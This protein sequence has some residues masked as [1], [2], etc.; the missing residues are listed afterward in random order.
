MR[1][2]PEKIGGKGNPVR[3]PAI[4]RFLLAALFS[5]F[6]PALAQT[7]KPLPGGFRDLKWRAH[8]TPGMKLVKEQTV[9]DDAAYRRPSD[10]KK[11]NGA[12]LESIT[13]SFYKGQLHSVAIQTDAGQGA[14]LLASLKTNWGEP[15][16]AAA[17]V[18]VWKDESETL[19]FF[20]GTALDGP[21][22]RGEL[23]IVCK[24]LAEEAHRA[25]IER[26][27]KAGLR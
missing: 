2:A 13:Y 5:S 26:R 23:F 20:R 18:F 22:S 21:D 1:R 10:V 6:L 27:E 8:P 15:S 11:M 16:Q 7:A 4:A 19:A 9:G 25:E 24:P 12:A 14:K 3:R 17:N